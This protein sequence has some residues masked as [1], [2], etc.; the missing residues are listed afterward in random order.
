[1]ETALVF[2]LILDVVFSPAVFRRSA[3]DQIVVQVGQEVLWSCHQ[4]LSSQH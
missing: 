2:I 1:M 3:E 4:I